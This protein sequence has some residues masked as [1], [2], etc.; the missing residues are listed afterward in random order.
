M[1]LDQLASL[2]QT[3]MWVQYS[4]IKKDALDALLFYRM[5]DFYE[6]F[7]DDAETAAGILGITHHARIGG[8]FSAKT[9]NCRLL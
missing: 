4:A 5:G 7:L 8:E 3:P 9:L 6:L 1:T 2:P